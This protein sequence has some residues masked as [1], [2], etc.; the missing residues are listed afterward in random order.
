MFCTN[1][2][3]ENEDLAKF[4]VSCGQPISVQTI[5]SENTSNNETVPIEDFVSKDDKLDNSDIQSQDNEVKECDDIVVE[6]IEELSSNISDDNENIVLEQAA[7][8]SEAVNFSE[9]NSTMPT[10][11]TIKKK[12]FLDYTGLAA[13]YIVILFLMVSF[14]GILIGTIS[15]NGEQ[16]KK[17]I[18]KI[19]ILEIEVGEIV[20]STDFEVEEDD[21]IKDIIYKSIK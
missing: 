8:T 19:D 14:I 21:N 5:E 7:I 17:D 16:I 4:C 1:C 18:N 10:Q 3:K 2:G 15:I 9:Q 11:N 20:E 12:G 13:C 6:P